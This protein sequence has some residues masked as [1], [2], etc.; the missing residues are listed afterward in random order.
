M[1]F[2]YDP[3]V[4]RE[5]QHIERLGVS[6]I[7]GLTD[8]I[9]HIF[10]KI[11]GTNA[12]IW[13]DYYGKICC[14]SRSRM[15]SMEPGMDN[16]GFCAWVNQ[17]DNLKRFTAFFTKY[18]NCKLYGEWLV[19]H[20]IKNY[21][22]EAWRNFYVFDVY[23]EEYIRDSIQ[24]KPC[25][26]EY[27]EYSK[28]CEEFNITYIPRIAKLDHPTD[29]E[30]KDLLSETHY[31]MEKETDFGEGIVIKRYDY[32]NKFKVVKFG[33]LITKD[34]INTSA[35]SSINHAKINKETQ[36]INAFL[37]E[38]ILDKIYCN[39]GKDCYL[40]EAFADEVWTTFIHE[41]AAHFLM[42]EKYGEG[43]INFSKLKAYVKK[44]ARSYYESHA[45]GLY[46]ID[47]KQISDYIGY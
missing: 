45:S 30:L 1:A 41:E 27:D 42:D 3:N 37:P 21:K 19:P 18:P 20:T 36:I 28:M 44:W 6:S 8:G 16:Y 32:K 26:I 9:C 29:I 35:N 5:Y 23:W 22:K 25:Y 7:A 14:G 34:C 2:A 4:F 17:P 10:P 12:S 43:N 33:K 11:D 39:F 31:L 38:S 13:R 40:I 46:D 47:S 24:S 15:L